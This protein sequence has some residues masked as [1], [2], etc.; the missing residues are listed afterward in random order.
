MKWWNEN[1]EMYQVKTEGHCGQPI[2]L[3]QSKE[4][5]GIWFDEMELFGARHGEAERIEVLDSKS[6]R[7]PTNIERRV[8]RCPYLQRV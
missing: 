1:T 4:C 8:L 7:T 3:E 2:L 5:G 6:L